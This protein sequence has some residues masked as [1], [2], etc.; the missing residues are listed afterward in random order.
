MTTTPRLAMTYLASSQADAEIKHNEALDILDAMVGCSV[1]DRDLTAPPTASE[2]EVYIVGPSA[3]GAWTSK[4]GKLAL[5]YH[6]QWVFI[7]PKE[8]FFAW[9]VDEASFIKYQSGSWQLALPKYDTQRFNKRR[10]RSSANRGANTRTVVGA[11]G[12]TPAGTL[13]NTADETEGSFQTWTTT[14]VNGNVAGNSIFTTGSTGSSVQ[15]R[16]KPMVAFRFKTPSDLS[17]LRI[18]LGWAA[19]S[20]GS[21][22]SPAVN[23][24]LLRYSTNASD[25][26]WMWYTYNGSSN[27]SSSQIASISTDTAY[28]VVLKAISGSIVEVWMGSDWD[29]ITRVATINSGLPSDTTDMYAWMTVTTLSAATRQIKFGQC[30]EERM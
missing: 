25:P 4:D 3:T 14:A 23:S 7:T 20:P 26:G 24:V 22:D 5:W 10:Y 18:M 30:E 28:L 21:S 13:G 16:Y 9:V 29:T 11:T 17:L 27:V 8:G 19:S 15:L 6:A 12:A 1:I 2:G